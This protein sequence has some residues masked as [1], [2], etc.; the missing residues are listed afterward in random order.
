MSEKRLVICG[1]HGPGQPCVAVCKHVLDGGAIGFVNWPPD[2]GSKI[3]SIGCALVP[4][5]KHTAEDLVILCVICAKR[6]LD[7]RAAQA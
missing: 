1:E 6:L 3:G 2:D 7:S 4:G 5:E